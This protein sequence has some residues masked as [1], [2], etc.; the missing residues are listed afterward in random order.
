M[1]PIMEKYNE[2]RDHVLSY[3]IRFYYYIILKPMLEFK[4]TILIQ[5]S[6]P[7]EH[8]QIEEFCKYEYDQA[9]EQFNE[10]EKLLQETE[11]QTKN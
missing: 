3:L 6:S 9:Q 10:E 4:K 11:T 2:F 5:Q 7:E 1:R 8:P